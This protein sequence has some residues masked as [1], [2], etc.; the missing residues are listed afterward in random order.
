MS[1]G[2]RQQEGPGLGVRA[3]QEGG[4]IIP[5]QSKRDRNPPRVFRVVD[6]SKEAKPGSLS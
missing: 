5:N 3:L 4:D 6:V 1:T 2:Q